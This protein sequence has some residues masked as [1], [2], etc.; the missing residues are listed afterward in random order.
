[1]AYKSLLMSRKTPTPG[2]PATLRGGRVAKASRV[3]GALRNQDLVPQ[4]GARLVGRITTNG[5]Y[6]FQFPDADDPTSLSQVYPLATDTR[7]LGRWRWTLA[8]GYQ[9]AVSL[10][11]LPTGPTQKLLALWLEAAQVGQ[12]IVA[13]TWSAAV[14][15][16]RTIEITPP[17]S[18]L[19]YKQVPADPWAALSERVEVIKPPDYVTPAEVAAFSSAAD[20]VTVEVVVSVVG[21]PRIVDLAVFEVPVGFAQDAAANPWP[22]HCFTNGVGQPLGGPSSPWPVEQVTAT[23]PTQGHR[24]AADVADEQARALG[25]I[26]YSWQAFDPSEPVTSLSPTPWQTMT[27]LPALEWY[28][29]T[30]LADETASGGSASAGALA[31]QHDLSGDVLELRDEDGVVPCRV[32]VYG[33]TD[34]AGGIG[35]VRVQV[36]VTSW[37]D[38]DVTS[39]TTQWYTATGD[40]RVGVGVES[41][42][43]LRWGGAVV[44]CA[45]LDVLA[46]V[47]EFA[48]R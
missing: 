18:P 43:T 32:H 6:S 40:L 44:T 9:P 34:L 39:P 36:G 29:G 33:N 3:G 48:R 7:E 23:D 28:E 16:T 37:I 30:D 38:V 20:P 47:V 4:H 45:Q 35:R 13:V 1:M 5:S 2:S 17:A 24:Q 25:P 12:V 14:S 46:I 26:L 15:A 22:A 21:S 31:R 41:T 10:I 27:S 19:Q 8:P 42:T 11:T